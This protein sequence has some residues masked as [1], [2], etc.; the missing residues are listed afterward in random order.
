MKNL[1]SVVAG[2]LVACNVAGLVCMLFF[3]FRLG[4]LLWVGSTVGGAFMLYNIRRKEEE[5]REAE[6]RMKKAGEAKGEDAQ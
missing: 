6:E 1:R 5:V 2:I 3:S 4:L